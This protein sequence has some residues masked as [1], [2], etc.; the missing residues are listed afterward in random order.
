MMLA[1]LDAEKRLMGNADFLRKLRVGKIA[2]FFSQEFC[3]LLV[4]VAL[5]NRKV[6]K[7]S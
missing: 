5:H 7:T 3:Q 4:Q 1:M 2:P 6:A